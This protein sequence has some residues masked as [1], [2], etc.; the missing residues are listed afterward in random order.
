VGRRSRVTA[1]R[2]RVERELSFD[3]RMETLE[4]MYEELVDARRAGAA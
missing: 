4:A 1:A 3:T 2:A